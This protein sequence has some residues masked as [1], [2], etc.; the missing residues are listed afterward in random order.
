MGAGGLGTEIRSVG[1]SVLAWLGSTPAAAAATAR[2]PKLRS[3]RNSEWSV[4]SDWGSELVIPS[5]GYEVGGGPGAGARLEGTSVMGEPLGGGL[6]T[7]MMKGYRSSSEQEGR[8]A[9][10]R[11]RHEAVRREAAGER[12]EGMA[13]ASVPLTMWWRATRSPTP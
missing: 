13:G 9:A 1:S 10:E 7:A 3:R 5:A 12:V 2:W 6:G 11:W 8:L 4:M